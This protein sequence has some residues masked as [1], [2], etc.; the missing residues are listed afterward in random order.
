VNN[1][2]G[3]GLVEMVMVLSLLG[4]IMLIAVPRVDR[5]LTSRDLSGAKAEIEALVR[6][7]QAAAVQHR[8][9]AQL[10]VDTGRAWVSVREPMGYRMIAS[11]E[12]GSSR[13]IAISASAPRLVVQPTG[14]VQSGT[15]FTIRLSKAGQTDSVRVV[16]YGRVE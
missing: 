14:L 9:S 15:P 13:G 4:I 11:V 3:I 7:G 12:L 10:E 1:V 8:R 2:R 6:R 16:A 5:A